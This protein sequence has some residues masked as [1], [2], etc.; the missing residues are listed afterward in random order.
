M[1]P[2]TKQIFSN[3]DKMLYGILIM[4]TIVT[5]TFLS[6]LTDAKYYLCPIILVLELIVFLCIKSQRNK[7]YVDTLV[8]DNKK[9]EKVKRK[10]FIL[11]I[12]FTLLFITLVVYVIYNIIKAGAL[13]FL[14]DL[15]SVNIVSFLIFVVLI[16][17][18]FIVNKKDTIEEKDNDIIL[19]KIPSKKLSIIVYTLFSLITCIIPFIYVFIVGSEFLIA[20][21]W[22]IG[23]LSNLLFGVLTS[24]ILRTAEY[25]NMSFAILG[26]S[27]MLVCL[28]GIFSQFES[29]VLGYVLFLVAALI[30]LLSTVLFNK[31]SKLNSILLAI[32]AI[33]MIV[34]QV[35]I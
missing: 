27:I 35:M 5:I 11:T 26:L 13:S 8:K 34:L 20:V 10:V 21:V 17:S 1:E 28:M 24:A 15:L 30:G 14:F 16:C 3:I 19:N 25:H 9:L 12:I 32:F 18:I 4:I 23:C 2:K 29:L 33:I 6:Y 7:N 31:N 22:V